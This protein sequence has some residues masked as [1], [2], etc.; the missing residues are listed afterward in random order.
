MEKQKLLKLLEVSDPLRVN[1]NLQNY[2]KNEKKKLF[3]STR[4]DKKYM[5]INPSGKHIHFGDINYQDFTNHQNID[6]QTR[7]LSRANKIKGNWIGNKYSPNNLSI[8][9][10]WQ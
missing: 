5:I 3:L 9:L 2:F 10:L 1:V 6:R 8:N 7:Y 4:K